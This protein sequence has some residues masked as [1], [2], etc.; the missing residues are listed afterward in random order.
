MYVL[1]SRVEF[2]ATLVIQPFKYWSHLRS[3]DL[4]AAKVMALSGTSSPTDLP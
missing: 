3:H 1:D 4:R 2:R